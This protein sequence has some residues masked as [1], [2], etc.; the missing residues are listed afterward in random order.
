MDDFQ[1]YYDLGFHHI[2]SAR[3]VEHMLLIAAIFVLY[4]AEDWKYI[5][6]MLTAFTV[7]HA[8]GLVF[9]TFS[10]L[11]I[12]VKTQAFIQAACVLCAAVYSLFAKSDE[13]KFNTVTYVLAICY[14][15]THAFGTARNLKYDD[16][17]KDL[18]P[19]LFS[20]NIGLEVGQIIVVVA[21][22]TLGFVLVGIAN[23]ERRDWKMVI[24]SA[25]SGVAVMLILDSGFI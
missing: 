22:M 19:H 14:A 20:F 8:V 24:A 13:A 17:T 7:G 21:F 15:I 3:G 5:L 4:L 6:L 25:I 18:A 11:T 1:I 23:V 10:P 2:F 9:A 16:G 12:P